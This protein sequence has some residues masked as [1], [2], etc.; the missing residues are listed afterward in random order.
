MTDN[1][2]IENLIK[3]LVRQRDS[4]MSKCAEL[5]AHLLIATQKVT[6]YENNKQAQDLFRDIDKD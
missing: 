2:F 6:D 4:A 3:V 1:L 5:E